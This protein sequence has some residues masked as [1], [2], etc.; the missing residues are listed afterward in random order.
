MFRLIFTC[1]LLIF[2]CECKILNPVILVPG[3]GGSEFVVKL[4]KTTAPH[5]WCVLYTDHYFSLWLNFVELL[6][7]V[8]DCFTNNTKLL[9]DREKHV[10]RNPSGVETKIPGWGDT[11]TVEWLDP[12]QISW[13][14]YFSS[15]VNA[16]VKWGYERNVSVRGAPYDFRKAPN[17]YAD[18]YQN[19]RNLVE[20]TYALNNNTKVVLLCHSMGSP[21]TLYF[22]NHQPQS[23]KD[24]FIQSF[25]SLA[26]VWGGS[27][28][29]LRLLASGDNL[30]VPFVKALKLRAQQRSMPSTAW[31]MPSDVFWGKDEVLIERPGRNYTVND[32]KQFFMNINFMDGWYMRQD[33]AN[34]IRLLKPPGVEVHCVHGYDIPTPKT[35][36]YTGNMWPDSQPNVRTELADGTVNI[37]SL[38][39][40]LHW[41]G[42]QP[43]KIYHVPVKYAEHREILKNK[44][45]IAYLKKTL[46][47]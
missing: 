1:L 19:L 23:W 13:T 46:T 6:P 15:I 44:D 32:Y 5:S 4:N 22:L 14:Y 28:K 17:E 40:C 12:S 24:K 33:T 9:Y 25:I 26:G 21:T 37:R 18:F 39:G 20:E 29:S 35:L 30:D 27:V 7:K 2:Y 36:V 11:Q 34:L 43:Q 47:S 42:K 38:K 16:M 10:T 3:D 45:V 41:Q 31:L 8:I